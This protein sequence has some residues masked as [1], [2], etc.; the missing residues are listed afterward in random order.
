MVNPHDFD[1][2][3]AW[4]F[5]CVTKETLECIK[6]V[7]YHNGIIHCYSYG[8]EEAKAF[9]DLG[10]YISLSGS[11]TYTKRSKMEAMKNLITLIPDEI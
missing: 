11:V 9:L 1:E 3:S 2:N 10:W 4:E 8:A 7:G 5:Y 6:E